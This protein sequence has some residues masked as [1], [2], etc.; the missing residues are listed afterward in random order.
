MRPTAWQRE[1]A[2][3][4]RA[5]SYLTDGRRLI[6]LVAQEGGATLLAEDCKSLELFAVPVSELEALGFRPVEAAG[7]AGPARG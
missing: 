2:P 6:R 3:G 5:G 1:R 7:G 4:Y